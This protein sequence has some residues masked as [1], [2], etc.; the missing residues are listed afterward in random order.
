MNEQKETLPFDA[1]ALLNEDGSTT[2]L[3]LGPMIVIVAA[4]VLI[5]VVRMLQRSRER[6]E[7]EASLKE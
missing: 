7:M 4:V 2:K 3:V 6:S 5:A 1:L